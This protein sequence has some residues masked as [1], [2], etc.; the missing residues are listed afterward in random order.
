VTIGVRPSIRRA[1]EEPLWGRFMTR[2]GLGAEVMQSVMA[3]EAQTD[4][5][6]GVESGRYLI[7]R[8]QVAAMVA[9]LAG[10]T[11][12]AMLPVLEGHGTWRKVGCDTAELL[13]VALGLS[14]DEARALAAGELPPLPITT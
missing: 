10:A 13:L 11:L 12:A 4:I 5:T 1:H 7:G 14:R 2:V 8:A 6:A 3:S 9:L